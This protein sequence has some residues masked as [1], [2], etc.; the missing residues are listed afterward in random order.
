MITALEKAML[1]LKNLGKMPVQDVGRK[2]GNQIK[3]T[4]YAMMES[5][6]AALGAGALGAGGTMMLNAAMEEDPEEAARKE[7]L[8]Q[9]MMQLESQ[10]EQGGGYGSY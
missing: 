7:R 8:K 9:I 3:D 2:F 4:G 1:Q 6:R 5:P 10:R